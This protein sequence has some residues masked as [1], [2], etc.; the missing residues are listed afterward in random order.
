M[1]TGRSPLQG[2]R[3]RELVR[4][5]A[6]ALK[7]SDL[8]GCRSFWSRKRLAAR[9][10]MNARFQL[11]IHAQIAHRLVARQNSP[12][13]RP[14]FSDNFVTFL[15]LNVTVLITKNWLS[16]TRLR[17]LLQIYFATGPCCNLALCYNKS[18]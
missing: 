1:S 13:W 4:S 9:P 3:S 16:G 10:P 11:G 14:A 8:I 18:E 7:R 15:N 2:I 12:K 6:Q 5:H 17:L